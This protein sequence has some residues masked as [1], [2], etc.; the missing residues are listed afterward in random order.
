MRS[1]P[2]RPLILKRRKLTLPPQDATCGAETP[3]HSK[4]PVRE[5]LDPNK[6]SQTHGVECPPSENTAHGTGNLQTTDLGKDN[7]DVGPLK[8]SLPPKAAAHGNDFL[9]EGMSGFPSGIRIMGHPTMS[10]T[11]I[12]VIPPQSDVQSIIQAL[13]ARGK[14]NGGPNKYIIISSDSP[15]HTGNPENQ[16]TCLTKKH[17]LGISNKASHPQ[18]EQLNASLS[19]IQWL[20]DMSSDSLG[21]C[22]KE[23]SEKENQPPEAESTKMEDERRVSLSSNGLSPFLSVPLLL[24]GPHSV[25]QSTAPRKR[26]TLKD[27][28]T[29]IE[30]HFPYFKQVAKP[31]WKVRGRSSNETH[32]LLRHNLSLHDMFVRET[33]T[34]NKISYWTIH[35]QANRC[36]TLDQVV[37]VKIGLELEIIRKKKLI[38]DITKSRQ[39][40]VMASS[41][42]LESLPYESGPSDSQRSS[43]R[44][45]IAPKVSVVLICFTF[46][47]KEEQEVLDPNCELAIQCKR[48]HSSRRK[49][50]LGPPR[51]EEP[52]LV[53]PDTSASDSG[54]DTEFSFLQ[55]TQMQ[56]SLP[57]NAQDGSSHLTHNGVSTFTQ[58]ET[59]LFTQSCPSQLTLDGPLQH[60]QDSPI[61][62]TQD[63]DCAFKT[64]IKERFSKPPSSSTPSKPMEAGSLHPWESE[65]FPPR[66]PVLDFSPVR[67]PHGTALTPF[68]D[69]FGTLSFGDTPFKDL[70]IFGSPQNLLGTGP[71]GTGSLLEGLVLDTIDESLSKIL[72]DIS[73]SGL[74]EDHGLGVD[75][76]VLEPVL[77]EFR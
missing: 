15:S 40:V 68:K 7:G 11:Q 64:P 42:A 71:L 53:L 27:I 33:I 36:L 22:I 69:S 32:K 46:V 63:E 21:P 70:P 35:P 51:S 66:D 13:T 77:P 10:D 37:K 55:D 41:K 65:T 73:F 67:L 59:S 76:C 8:H 61:Q 25:L 30:D 2:R 62:L 9:A 38:S 4:A 48:V 39:N 23:E 20:G 5:T 31:G 56:G 50:Q 28:Y 54:L 72:L 47:M 14:E 17:S 18:A 43:K 60:T 57:H 52:E 44:V 1:S 3:D 58:W 29:W 45:K 16:T 49:Q 26:M 34:N 75:G 19:N 24:H 6:P 12:V 74:E